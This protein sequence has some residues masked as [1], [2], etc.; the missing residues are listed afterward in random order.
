MAITRVVGDTEI[1][2]PVASKRLAPLTPRDTTPQYRLG[3]T[4]LNFAER[5]IPQPA[6]TAPP[7][8]VALRNSSGGTPRKR[9]VGNPIGAAIS[10][11]AKILSP[12]LADVFSGPPDIP[13]A[14]GAQLSHNFP[15]RAAPVAPPVAAPIAAPPMTGAGLMK[16]GGFIRR[17]G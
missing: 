5:P 13:G 1:P 15:G 8:S 4:A 11:A 12:A 2:R 16:D 9:E 7:P 3:K 6:R 14:S 10:R 17:R